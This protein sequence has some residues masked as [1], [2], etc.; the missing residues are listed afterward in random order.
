MKN[1]RAIRRM[2]ALVVVL[3]AGWALPGR[4][5]SLTNT[6]T[7]SSALTDWTNT[8]QVAE[9]SPHVGLLLSVDLRVQ[10]SLDTKFYL[11]NA[12]G[13]Q[14]DG[15]VK[16]EV[17]ISVLDD[18]GY[19]S[20][21]APQIDKMFPTTPYS[22]HLASG[23]YSTSSTYSA[24]SDSGWLTYTDRNALDSFT[25]F[26]MLDLEGLTKTTTWIS[27]TGGNSD[28]I[29]KT[30]ANAIAT[31][32]YTYVIPE[33]GTLSLAT[34]VGGAFFLRFHRR[35]RERRLNGKTLDFKSF[36]TP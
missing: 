10:T 8:Q 21:N 32:I 12:S 17:M 14:S 13:L 11:H 34:L 6:A 22:Y 1:A 16:A 25:G 2:G 5:S 36:G 31:I 28:V 15:T 33:P 20:A 19:F 29:Q 18:A 3:A 35:R 26:G 30:H 27:Y 9:F 7:W 4:A 23:A 24:T